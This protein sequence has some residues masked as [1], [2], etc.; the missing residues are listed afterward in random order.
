MNGCDSVVVMALTVNEAYVV[1]ETV[2]LCPSELPFVWN[3]LTFTESGTQSIT[4]QTVNGCDSVLTMTVTVNSGYT[5]TETMFVCPNELPYEWNGVTFTAAGIQ[6]VTLTAADGCDSVVTMVLNI[7]PTFMV[8]DSRTICPSELPYEWNGVTFTAAG[9][10]ATSLQ[11]VNGC[12]SIVVMTLTVHD[13]VTSEF[14]IETSDSCYEWNGMVYCTS[15]NYTQTFTAANGCDSVV[16]LH[17][18]TSVGIGTHEPG[19]SLY[20]AP[21]PA[22][23]ISRII[24]LDESFKYVN[25]MDMRGRLVLKSFDNE[26]DVSTLP[27]GVYVV[28]VFTESGVKNLKLVK[29]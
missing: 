24:G 12:D 8:T 13:A 20:L 10:Q 4:L 15:G 17:L 25:V 14:T 28:K 18:T 19:T 7:N 11:T 16:T 2:A 21:N 1:N 29:Q 3:G 6:N 27:A 9:V 26:I 5:V 23:N 22:K